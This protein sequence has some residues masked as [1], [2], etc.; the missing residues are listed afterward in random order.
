V[1][2]SG[3]GGASYVNTPDALAAGDQYVRMQGRAVWDTAVTELP[4][5]IEQAVAQAGLGL[6]DIDYFVVHQANL[7]LINEVLRRLGV[8]SNRAGITVDMLGNTGSAG[9]YTVLH[10]A[11]TANQIKRGDLLVISA[12][13]AGFIWGTLC[14]RFC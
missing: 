13:G 4:K 11:I 6:R 7:N 1:W 9:V 5:S 10:N 12:I 8:E 3:P 2:R 14:L